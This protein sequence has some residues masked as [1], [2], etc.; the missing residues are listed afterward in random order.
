VPGGVGTFTIMNLKKK[1]IRM[2]SINVNGKDYSVDV[3][4]DTPLLWVI[5]EELKLNGTK[6]AC[7]VGECGSCTVHIDGKAERSCTISVGDVNGA[8]ITTIE[9]LSE[10]HPVKRAW[11]E[12]QVV[13]CGYC[14][15][16]IMMEAASLLAESPKPDADKIISS[17]DDVICRCGTYP[18]IK[19]GVK[20][21]VELMSKEGR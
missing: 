4:S 19:K 16:G 10:D 17:M 20:K 8:K 14:Q 9:G 13:Q 1:E 3:S 6:Y 2:I 21:A 11:I 12:E 18:R 5:R 7:G 15:P